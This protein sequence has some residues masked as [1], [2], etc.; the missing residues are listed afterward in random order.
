MMGKNQ[1]MNDYKETNLMWK[2]HNDS[3]TEIMKK[4]EGGTREEMGKTTRGAEK[5]DNRF[6]PLLS[7]PLSILLELVLNH[8]SR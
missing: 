2:S 7:P 8:C 4:K 1:E 3:G 5:I 6:S